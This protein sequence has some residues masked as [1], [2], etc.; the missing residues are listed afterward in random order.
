MQTQRLYGL[1]LHI[2]KVLFRY[3]FTKNL[4]KKELKCIRG[5]GF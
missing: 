5:M 3:Y 2:L 1:A 4:N